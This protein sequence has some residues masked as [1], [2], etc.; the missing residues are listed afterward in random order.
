METNEIFISREWLGPWSTALPQSTMQLVKRMRSLY[1]Y[2]C[3]ILH[4]GMQR[5]V[6]KTC[7]KYDT[8]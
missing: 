6:A 1:M 5:Q 2:M 7:I 8:V 3:G 4:S